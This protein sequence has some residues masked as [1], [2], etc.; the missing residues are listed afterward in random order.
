MDPQFLRN[1]LRIWK[2]PALTG[3]RTCGG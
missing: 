3:K 1:I 2:T